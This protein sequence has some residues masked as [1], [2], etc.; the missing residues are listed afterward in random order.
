MWMQ[1][2]H[3]S[4]LLDL[5]PDRLKP[6]VVETTAKPLCAHNDAFQMREGRYLGDR[7]DDVR[8]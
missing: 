3:Q 7:L 1:E 6:F 8:G 4:V 5:S 2:H